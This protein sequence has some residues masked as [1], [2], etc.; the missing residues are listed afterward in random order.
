[1][2]QRFSMSFICLVA[3]AF[4]NVYKPWTVE[5]KIHLVWDNALE[6]CC[7]TG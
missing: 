4:L 6:V 7:G 3:I 2:S 1:M 5:E